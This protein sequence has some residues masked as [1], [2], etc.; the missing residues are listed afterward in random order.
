M[1]AEQEDTMLTEETNVKVRVQVKR[2]MAEKKRVH[3]A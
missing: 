3:Q 2:E 1:H